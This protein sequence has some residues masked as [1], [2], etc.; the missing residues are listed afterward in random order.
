MAKPFWADGIRFECQGT[1]RCCMSRGQYGYVYLSLGDRQRMAKHLGLSTRE[2][3]RKYCKNTDGWFHLKH[4]ERDCEF[5]KGKGCSVY[6]ARPA[7]CRTWPFWP[8]NLKAKT[9]NTEVKA[10]CP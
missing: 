2:F 8:E 4:P 10:F 6:E 1:G 5:L 9:W 7:Q 3:T